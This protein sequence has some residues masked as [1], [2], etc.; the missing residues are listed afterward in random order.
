MGGREPIPL[1]LAELRE[2]WIR[3][4]LAS[5]WYLSQIIDAAEF[6]PMFRS[7]PYARHPKQRRKLLSRRR[8]RQ[9]IDDVRRKLRKERHDDPAEETRLAYERLMVAFQIAVDHEDVK[10]M[11]LVQKLINRMIGIQ[12]DKID[13]AFDPESIRSQMQ[14]MVDATHGA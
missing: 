4:K 9:L 3:T 1:D 12:R 5:G 11:A 2:S 13:V 14:G 10:G 8:I 6:E 7:V